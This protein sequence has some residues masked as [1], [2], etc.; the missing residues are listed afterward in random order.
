MLYLKKDFDKAV[1]A[2]NWENGLN[3]Y[4]VSDD[5]RQ[6][7]FVT[8]LTD[9][10]GRIKQI[11]SITGDNIAVLLDTLTEIEKNMPKKRKRDLCPPCPKPY[12]P[13]VL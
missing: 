10:L 6:E 9:L 3:L 5:E 11:Q 2:D 1:L 12:D 7:I 4:E 8:E 13:S